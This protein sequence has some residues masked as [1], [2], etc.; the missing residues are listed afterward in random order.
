MKDY[1]NIDE[2][3]CGIYVLLAVEGS[4]IDIPSDS[5]FLAL[6]SHILLRHHISRSNVTFC[7]LL[8]Y[9]FDILSCFFLLLQRKSYLIF[10]LDN[11][12]EKLH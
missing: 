1:S 2:K 8:L 4:T 11:R 7:V 5:A 9:S 10:L 6:N 12:K 3:V